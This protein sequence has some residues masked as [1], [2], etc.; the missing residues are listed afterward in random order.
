MLRDVAADDF[1]EGLNDGI[2]ANTGQTERDAIQPQVSEATV[3]TTIG[4]M[5]EA[6]SISSEG[7]P[8][9]PSTA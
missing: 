1:L 2:E 3:V 7:V 8:S 5:K 9:S 4:E 6:H